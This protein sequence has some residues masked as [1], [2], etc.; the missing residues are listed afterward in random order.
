MVEFD[1]IVVGAGSAGCAVAASLAED[2]ARS[3]L[4][5]EA[6]GS[7]RRLEVRAP[8]AYS[9]QM[10]G[11]TDWAFETEP[12]PGCDGRRLYQPRGKVLGGTSAMNAMV[13]VRGCKAD[14]DGWGVP[15]WSWAEVAPVFRRMESHYLSGDSHGSSGPMKVTRVAEPDE[16]AIRFVEAARATGVPA[17]E[18]VGGPDLDGAAI[19]PV[20]VWRGRRWSTA[21]GYLDAARRRR[22][23][24]VITGALV[25]RVLIR[26]GRAVAVEYSR[27]GRTKVAGARAEVVLSAGASGTPHLLQLSGV[28]PA[29]H[30]RE[31][32]IMPIVDS[33]NV[34]E[35]LADHPATFMN[36]ELA[37]GFT[38]LAD[39]QHPKWLLRWLLRR[40]GKLTSNFMEAVAHIRSA[41]DLDAPDFQLINGPAY[42]WDYGRATHPRP[43]LAILQSLWAPESRGT[44]LA[45]SANPRQPPAIRMNTL[46]SPA[47]V[48]A[49]VRAIRRTREIVAADPLASIVATELHPGPEVTSDSELDAW[50]RQTVGSAGHPACTAAMGES[51][52]SV[53]D[54]RLRVRAVHS[55]RVA[56]ASAFPD[57]PHA[58][59][60]APAILFG[61]R[62]ADFMLEERSG[63]A[64]AATR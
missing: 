60:N 64:R 62:C 33:P 36:W 57:I 5:L 13:W 49:F 1:Y 28:G 40:S 16:V 7:D 34:G 23:L 53:L 2:S 38:G 21:R 51:A 54:E 15:G 30:L 10:R 47:D 35:N 14:Y 9:A 58:N 55:L 31:V 37:P 6:G 32:G 42:V 50:V 46:T 39:A 25:H 22:N 52:D 4:L 61:E 41:P 43:A 44:V 56:D 26:D 11:S 20:T 48:A 3:V 45:R 19:S 59:T 12:E 29:G 17:N 63:D 27:A 24:T 8:L 18:D